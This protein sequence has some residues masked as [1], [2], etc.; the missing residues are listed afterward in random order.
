MKWI[1]REKEMPPQSGWYLTLSV[2]YYNGVESKL[3]HGIDYYHKKLRKFHNEF[4][5]DLGLIV[6]RKWIPYPDL[7]KGVEFWIPATPD[8]LLKKV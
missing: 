3:T 5:N 2:N 8:F 4:S 1:D 7:P 6:V